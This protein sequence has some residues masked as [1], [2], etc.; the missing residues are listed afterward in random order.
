LGVREKLDWGA[1]WQGDAKRHRLPG[2]DS[3]DMLTGK[4]APVIAAL[5]GQRLRAAFEKNG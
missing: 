5:L 3:G 4:N 2:K 1:L